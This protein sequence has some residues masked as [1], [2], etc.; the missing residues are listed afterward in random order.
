MTQLKAQLEKYQE[1]REKEDSFA[2]P[3]SELQDVIKNQFTFQGNEEDTVQAYTIEKSLQ[4][5][6]KDAF[7][8][9]PP[10]KIRGIYISRT[11]S[12]IG[13]PSTVQ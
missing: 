11:Q 4:S 12:R 9:P 10:S 13:D 8:V 2:I 7:F 1:Q 5:N 6:Y 3:P